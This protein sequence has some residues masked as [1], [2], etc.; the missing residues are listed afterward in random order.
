[1]DRARSESCYVE[2][3]PFFA[4]PFRYA[5]AAKRRFL[6]I[7]ATVATAAFVSGCQHGGNDV[8]KLVPVPRSALAAAPLAGGRVA[9]LAG[10]SRTKAVFIVDTAR[11]MVLSSFGVAAESSGLSAA[12]DQGPLLITIAAGQGRSARGALE[13]WT[14]D[15]TRDGSLPLPG[16]ALAITQTI[17]GTAYVLDASGSA[18]SATAVDVWH[19]TRGEPIPLAG[20]VASLQQCR[21]RDNRILAYATTAHLITTR[22]I[23]SGK[24]VHSTARGDDPGCLDGGASLYAVARTVGAANLVVLSF[25][26]LGQVAAV[27]LSK[28]VVALYDAG[29]DRLMALNST[30]EV[31]T[32]EILPRAF[33]GR[34]VSGGDRGAVAA[35]AGS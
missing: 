8:R 24:E 28:A 13:R 5:P 20:D 10:D 34:A 12:S 3:S 6:R 1:V 7:L 21:L 23:G 2:E 32:L 14:V 19:L 29:G 35:T 16:P 33:D 25:P 27:P 17:D 26:G 4:P 15:G 9:I 30:A 11:E 18:R 22:D 31:G